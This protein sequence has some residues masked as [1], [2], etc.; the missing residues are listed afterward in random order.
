MSGAPPEEPAVIYVVLGM[1][2]SGTTLVSQTLHK[3]GVSM[4]PEFDERISYDEGNQWERRSSWLINL[5]IVGA[6]EPGYFSLDWHRRM[7]G[8]P[9]ESVAARMRELCATAAGEADDWGFKD[10]LT[11]LT[12]AHWRHILPEHRVIAVY[13]DPA[14]VMRHYRCRD[15][16]VLRAWRVLRAWSSY[17]AGI[18]DAL[19][20]AGPRGLCVRYD[21]LM[22][23]DDE[24]NRLRAFA[25]RPLVD[26]R[27]A[28]SYRARS[29]H[30]LYAPVGRALAAAT[31]ADPF[32][33]LRDLEQTRTATGPAEGP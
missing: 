7:G 1:H 3:S 17:N 13:R 15:W 22:D 6:D 12:Y 5:D 16:D 8:A 14:E 33:I 24:L 26:V 2:K 10:P 25:G 4:G 32:R 23:G 21:A 29:R 28:S 30:P 19:A 11:C 9:D 31:G 18:L 27:R 20:H